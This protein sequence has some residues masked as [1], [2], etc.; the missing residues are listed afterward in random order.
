MTILILW[1]QYNHY[2]IITNGSK[3]DR[4]SVESVGGYGY[5]CS[6]MAAVVVVLLLV[7]VVIS[8]I[9]VSMNQRLVF[10]TFPTSAGKSAYGPGH[11]LAINIL[12][13]DQK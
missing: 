7:V 10:A 3:G 1:T 8:N 5:S 2:K 9:V 6:Y 13:C 4:K 11:T 12:F